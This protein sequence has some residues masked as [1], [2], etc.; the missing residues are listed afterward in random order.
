[1]LATRDFGD[2][3][4]KHRELEQS[5]KPPGHQRVHGESAQRFLSAQRFTALCAIQ[6]VAV[7][8]RT[9]RV[10]TGRRPADCQDS[11]LKPALDFMGG[12]HAGDKSEALAARNAL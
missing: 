11:S 1:M 12:Q 10:K 5:G 2:R 3:F 6:K 7:R 9:R 4:P 8:D